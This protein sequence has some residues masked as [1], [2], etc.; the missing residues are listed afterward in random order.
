MLSDPDLVV[1]DCQSR[2][3]GL[4]RLWAAGKDAERKAWEAA[5]D[6]FS[7]GRLVCRP[8]GKEWDQLASDEAVIN[9]GLRDVKG[10]RK[11]DT[12][13]DQLSQPEMLFFSAS[14]EPTLR[15]EN[16]QE[17]VVR[18]YTFTNTRAGTPPQ[19]F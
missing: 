14:E 3:K 16:V 15:F 12:T 18:A 2:C 11:I 7:D 4:E 8:V 1:F 6:K 5:D 17:C 9:V 19:G 10:P 13:I